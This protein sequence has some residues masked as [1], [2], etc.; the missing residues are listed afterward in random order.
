MYTIYNCSTYLQVS[1]RNLGVWLM[2]AATIEAAVK[3]YL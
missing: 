2:K 3:K 1:S